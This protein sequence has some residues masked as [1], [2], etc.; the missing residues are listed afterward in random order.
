MLRGGFLFVGWAGQWLELPAAQER[1]L[2]EGLL[3]I[4]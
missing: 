3:L 1:S 4:N 2:V